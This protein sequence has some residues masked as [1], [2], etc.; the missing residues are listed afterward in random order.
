MGTLEIDILIVVLL[1]NLPVLFIK[2][3]RWRYILKLQSISYS[4]SQTFISYLSGLF[5]GIVTPGRLGEAIKI[6]YLKEDQG[7]PLSKGLSGVLADRL[8]DLCFLI[9]FGILGIWY[10]RIFGQLNQLTMIFIFLA[11]VAI[12]IYLI[13]KNRF[14]D[15]IV[16]FFGQK[17]DG[18]IIS[19]EQFLTG[20]KDLARPKIILPGFLTVLSYIVY[21]IQCHLILLSLSI[22]I[23]FLMTVFLMSLINLA[24]LVPISILGIGTREAAMIYLFALINIPKEEAIAFSSVIFAVFYVFGGFFGYGGWILRNKISLAKVDNE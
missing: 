21:F 20:F 23:D 8:F 10:L 16:S 12:F 11:I 2:S 18:L 24:S 1:L 7:I 22:K 9:L 5:V 19:L 13:S 17:F 14:K 3:L 6:F 4:L 15:F